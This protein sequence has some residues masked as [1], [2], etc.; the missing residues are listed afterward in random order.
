MLVCMTHVLDKVEIE[1]SKIDWAACP[2]V[3]IDPLKLGGTPILKDTRMPAYGILENFLSGSPPEE[4]AENFEIP[5]QG[6]RDI[7]GYAALQNS[8]ITF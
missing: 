7:L 8:A 5:E 1:A 4:I 6:V 2:V 3:E